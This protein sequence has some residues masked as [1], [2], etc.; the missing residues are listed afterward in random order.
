MTM[1]IVDHMTKNPQSIS[2]RTSISEAREILSARKFRHLPVVD[3]QHQLIGMVTDRDLRSAYPS[4]VLTEEEKQACIAMISEKP[5]STIMSTKFV[6]LS[7]LSTLDDALFLL[8]RDKVGALPVLDDQGHVIGIF[9]IRDLVKAYKQIYGLGERGSALVVIEDDGCENPLTRIVETLESHNINFTRLVRP[10][11][12]NRQDSPGFIYLRVNTYN[13]NAV[14][15]ALR[16]AGF[17]VTTP[18]PAMK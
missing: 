1:Y 13:L 16:K 11:Y 9:S 17:S 7:H 3:E 4:S 10:Q 8:D 18:R 5:V 2:P 14:H 12:N 6:T 15:S